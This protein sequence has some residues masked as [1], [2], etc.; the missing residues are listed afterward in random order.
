MFVK[1]SIIVLSALIIILFP[2]AVCYAQSDIVLSQACAWEQ[3]IDV[4]IAGDMN[5]SDLSCKASNQTITV[6]D[7]G[8]LADKGVTVRTTILLDISTSI[9]SQM[10]ESIVSYIELL[11]KNISKNEQYKLVTFGEQLSVLQDFT[12][13]RYDLANAA[14]KIEFNG[15]QSKIYDAIYNTIPMVQPIDG[16]P[17]YYR[18]IAIT[19]GVDDTASGVTKEE[20]YLKLQADTYPID[21][22]AVS[23]AKQAEPVK[24]LSA[25]IRMSG[26]KYVNL[27]AETD[28][29]ELISSLA[30]SGVF[31]LRATIP[32]ALLDGSK[33]Q[34]D[35][36]DG[37]NFIQFDF[38]VP[39]F[40]VPVIETPTPSIVPAEEPAMVTSP[41]PTGIITQPPP[42]SR[43]SQSGDSEMPK[44]SLLL[45]DIFEEYTTAAYV[46]TVAVAI[47]LI[48]IIITVIVVK[49]KKK[50]SGAKRGNLYSNSVAFSQKTEIIGGDSPNTAANMAEAGELCVRLR[51]IN[52]PDQIWEISLSSGVLIGRDTECQVCIDERSM[53][54]RQCRLYVDANG[55]PTAENLSSANVT[56]LNG[57]PLTTLRRISESDK[58]K[59]GRV[60]LMIDSLYSSSSGNIGNINKMTEFVNI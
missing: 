37:V 25:L 14:D 19:D 40:E 47:I 48:A 24:E 56:Y 50:K 13:D 51:N 10:R 2:A 15:Q 21:I 8:L 49:G 7:G 1:R 38:K 11:I 41:A 39:V 53:S 44:S 35:I 42:S 54:R 3:N 27:N 32:G 36:S 57:E 55:I 45:A 16:M 17:C 9:P 31:W 52:N 28:L 30:V 4:Y 23:K 34:F 18:T 59:C 46:G 29:Q 5:T 22:V 20:L 12:S 43:N 6:V 26:G 58:L 33:R 60:T